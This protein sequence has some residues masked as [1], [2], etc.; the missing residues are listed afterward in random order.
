MQPRRSATK[1]P[2][3]RWMHAE[4]QVLL[5]CLASDEFMQTHAPSFL[6]GEFPVMTVREASIKSSEQH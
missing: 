1:G 3:S 4:L 5:E 6:A 2:P